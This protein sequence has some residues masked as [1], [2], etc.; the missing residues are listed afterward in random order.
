MPRVRNKIYCNTC[1][2]LGLE[3]PAQ[4]RKEE[5]CS[6]HGAKRYCRLCL[7]EKREKFLKSLNLKIYVRNII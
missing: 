2:E 3:N 5:L 6:K 4:A 1:L 7:E